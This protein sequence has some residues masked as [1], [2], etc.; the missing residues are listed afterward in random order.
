IKELQR[1]FVQNPSFILHPKPSFSVA[2]IPIL[3]SFNN[4]YAPYAGVLIQSI[5]KNANV[6]TNYDIFIFGS[7]V[8]QLNK[9]YINLITSHKSNVNVTFLDPDPLFSNYDL[10]SYSHFSKDMYYRLFIPDVFKNFTRVIYIDSDTLVQT[11]IA[12]LFDTDMEGKSIAAVRDCVM[13]GFIKF[14]VRSNAETGSLEAMDYLRSYLEIED[15]CAYF[16][17][18]ILI[19]DIAK[20]QAKMEQV[21]SILMS[22]K[23]YWFPDQDILNKVYKNDVLYLDPRWNVYHGNGDTQT[24]FQNLPAAVAK[25]YFESR[26]DPFVIH[27]AGPRKP[28]IFPKVDFASY[29]WSVARE[30]PWYEELLLNLAAKHDDIKGIDHRTVEVIAHRIVNEKS[31]GIRDVMRAL[32]S[33][34]APIGSTRRNILRKAFNVLRRPF[35]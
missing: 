15:D 25:T 30:T 9:N 7:N 1:T 12:A 32:A 20:S 8:S 19:F 6:N 11:D 24:F 22:G 31:I 34:F 26:N 29:F 35:V 16:Q 2:N 14:K 13:Q 33:P 10:Y 21:R 4:T 27:F 5:I 3:I 17:S 28:W 18:G 23:K